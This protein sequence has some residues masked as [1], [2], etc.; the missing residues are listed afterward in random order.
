MK[1]ELVLFQTTTILRITED[2]A[3]DTILV[4]LAYLFFARFL[5]LLLNV[6]H[7]HEHQ[8]V[9]DF[10]IRGFSYLF[11]QT[12]LKHQA[13]MHLGLAPSQRSRTKQKDLLLLFRL[14]FD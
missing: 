3:V 8:N 13:H 9:V 10:F 7:L 4:L 12:V 14:G 5:L 1:I 6:S 2:H 11:I